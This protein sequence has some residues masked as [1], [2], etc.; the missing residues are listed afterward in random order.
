MTLL[1]GLLFIVTDLILY[2]YLAKKYKTY[3]LFKL[4]KFWTKE[5]F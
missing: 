5:Y 3:N 4:A 2:F 1:F